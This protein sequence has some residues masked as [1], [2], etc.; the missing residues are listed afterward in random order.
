MLRNPPVMRYPT[1]SR[2]PGKVIA[3]VCAGCLGVFV[4]GCLPKALGDETPGQQ[5]AKVGIAAPPTEQ[6]PKVLCELQ[7]DLTGDGVPDTVRA[8]EVEE[9]YPGAE[10]KTYHLEGGFSVTVPPPARFRFKR[11]RIEV[12]RTTGSQSPPDLTIT[13]DRLVSLDL[14]H[15]EGAG[16]PP[17]LLIMCS[18][19]DAP[20]SGSLYI[21][22]YDRKQGDLRP[23][24]SFPPLAGAEVGTNLREGASEI[25][26]TRYEEP[27]PDVLGPGTFREV[28]RW[29][30]AAREWRLYRDSLPAPAGDEPGNHSQ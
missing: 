8:T 14:L 22:F 16:E 12:S 5:P 17:Q 27:R 6:P 13:T 7:A 19:H 10:P 29:D 30:P 15:V 9:Y 21:V 2:V 24:L 26:V 4:A 25:T 28:Y 1:S 20:A 23:A 18:D 3:A 11:V